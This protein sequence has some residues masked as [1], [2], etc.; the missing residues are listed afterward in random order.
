MKSVMLFNT[1][2]KADGFLINSPHYKDILIEAGLKD[3]QIHL[4]KNVRHV[5]QLDD[6]QT[7]AN[8]IFDFIKA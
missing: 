3:S 6:P 7:T 1:L 4:L 2:S 8:L 5:P